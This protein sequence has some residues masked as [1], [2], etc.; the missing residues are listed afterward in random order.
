M[1]DF[2]QE[3]EKYF[4]LT[5]DDWQV[6]DQLFIARQLAKNEY[7]LKSGEV[8]DKLAFVTDG[9]LRNFIVEGDGRE[10]TTH[11]AYEKSIAVSFYSFKKQI[12]SFENIQATEPTHLLEISYTNLD[13][14]LRQSEAFRSVYYAMIEEA[15][16]C[17]E[18]RNYVLQNLSAIE[19][20]NYLIKEES[21]FILRKA[22][23]GHISS[24]LGI[25][26]ETL[27][28]VRRTMMETAG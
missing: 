11:F 19:K 25:N 14:L 2:R 1:N 4:P 15:Y 28:R 22:N 12:S 27:S 24:Y 20:Y 16:A 3:F 21:P 6:I 23:L 9:F 5:D 18:R 8:C 17:M 26:Q 10:I 7:W 13:Q